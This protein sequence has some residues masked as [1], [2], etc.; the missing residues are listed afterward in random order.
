MNLKETHFTEM[1][2]N[3]S[4]SL[5]YLSI[6]RKLLAVAEKSKD[7]EGFDGF[8]DGFYP[9]GKYCVVHK[10]GISPLKI[11][12]N[13]GDPIKLPKII[14]KDSFVINPEKLNTKNMVVELKDGGKKAFSN[15]SSFADKVA[16]KISRRLQ[17]LE[18]NTIVN[19]LIELA[20]LRNNEGNTLPNDAYQPRLLGDAMASE[21]GKSVI[22]KLIL[23]PDSE[24]TKNICSSNNSFGY[25]FNEGT[26]RELMTS[27]LFGHFFT[28]DVHLTDSIDTNLALLVRSA[29]DAGVCE[30]LSKPKIEVASIN[31]GKLAEVRFE[32]TI[33]IGLNEHASKLMK[34]SKG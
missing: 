34:L 14:L 23:N 26:V 5:D 28:A 8:Y 3:I 21:L 15:F 18:T 10:H 17:E 33:S 24:I 2:D 27:N 7:S 1:A 32:E 13:F 22:S 9:D 11:N 20:L 25:Q 4:R 6:G 31:D 12:E 19:A 29:D 16:K 30:I